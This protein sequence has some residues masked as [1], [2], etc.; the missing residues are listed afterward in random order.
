MVPAELRALFPHTA[1][2]TYVNHAAVS[3]ISRPV[4]TAIDSFVK[5]R[6]GVTRDG[7]IANFESMQTVIEETKDRAAQLLG[8]VPAQIEFVPNTSSGLN[9]LCG[10]LDWKARDRVA[11]PDGSF[12][13][14]VYPFLNLRSQ[15]VSVDFVPTD[16]G[17][18]SIE[19]VEKTLRPETRVLSVSWV[20]FLSGF[21]ANL[22]ELGELCTENDVLF[23]VDAIQGLGALEIDVEDA[24]IDFLSCGGHKWLMATQGVGLLYCNDELQKRLRPPSGWLH[25]PVDWENLSRYDLTFHEDARKFRTGTYNSLGIAALHAA[26]GLH[27]ECGPGWCEERVLK[28]AGTLAEELR[29]LGARLYGR[30]ETDRGSGIVTMV[31]NEPERLFEYLQAHDIIAAM[32][33][34]KIRF[35]P[36]YY[37]D[38]S[39]L[40]EIVTAVDSFQ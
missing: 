19:D 37:N 40:R 8:A 13:A 15:G 6:Q 2:R 31:P 4:Q 18:Y 3:P 36:T 34:R 32:R 30:R 10:G 23:C 35:S 25:G 27:L 17:A 39:D 33:N 9:L 14:N 11:I 22:T 20:H 21:R 5:E 38:E 7:C 1:D 28:L 26:L 29:E 24:G 12:P 16:E